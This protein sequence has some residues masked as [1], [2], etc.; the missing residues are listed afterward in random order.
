MAKQTNDSKNKKDKKPDLKKPKFSPYWI[1]GSIFVIFL[2]L[3]LSGGSNFS[4]TKKKRAK[5]S[6][7][8]TLDKEMFKKLRL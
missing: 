6:L 7:K 5:L 8:I 2:A 3:Q 1:Y 4:Q